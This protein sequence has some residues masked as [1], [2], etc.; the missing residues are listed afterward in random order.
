[1]RDELLERLDSAERHIRELQ[2]E[3]E[4]LRALAVAEE[5]SAP[6]PP[7]A[8]EPLLAPAPET[9]W[10]QDERGRWHEARPER[11]GVLVGGLHLFP[12]TQ[13][14]NNSAAVMAGG[15]TDVRWNSEMW[16][17]LESD[18]VRS[19]LYRN[20]QSNF[21]FAIGLYHTF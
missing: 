11:G 18:Y 6:E 4:A 19:Q 2:S 20:V 14:S 5:P 13:F 3:L 7:P 1:M 10:W 17:R 16:V 9:G 12:Q 21:Q 8:P 15:G